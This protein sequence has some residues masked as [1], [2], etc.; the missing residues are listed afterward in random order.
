M[1]SFV[2]VCGV[3]RSGTTAFADLLNLHP[4][5]VVGVERFKHLALRQASNPQFTPEVFTK[6][7]FFDFR[8]DDTNIVRSYDAEKYES[9]LWVGDKVPRYYRHARTIFDR[10]P[11]AV[12]FYIVRGPHAVARSWNERS[13]NPGDSW[14]ETNNYVRAVEEWNRANRLAL[15][16]GRDHPFHIVSYEDLFS[17][18]AATITAALAKLELAP[19]AEMAASPASVR[20]TRLPD[21]E[22]LHVEANAQWD[23]YERLKRR[24]LK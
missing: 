8:P 24:S 15:R 17:G 5:I 18:S 22:R 2:F 6:S 14:P 23:I 13:K 3:P 4:Q 16:L 7:R 9:A 20:V 12:M 10:F 19:T 11:G 21:E 1:P